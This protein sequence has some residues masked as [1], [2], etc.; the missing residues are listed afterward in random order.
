MS[1][2]L[3][4]QTSQILR[5]L[6][7]GTFTFADFYTRR[8]RRIVPALALVATATLVAGWIWFFPTNYRDLG[9]SVAML[10]AFASNVFS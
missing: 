1:V 10:A 6:E 3:L 5:D 8:A 2:S 9:R 4:P 7:Q